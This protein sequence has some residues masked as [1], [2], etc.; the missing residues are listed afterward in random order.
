MILWKHFL[1]QIERLNGVWNFALDPDGR[2][3]RDRWF[4]KFPDTNSRMVV[5]SCW[6][7]LPELA[8]YHGKGWFRRCLHVPSEKPNLC[9]TFEGTG[10]A[11]TAWFDGKLLGRN[12][13]GC[14]PWTLAVPSVSSGA[15]ELVVMVDNSKNLEEAFPR[16]GNDWAHYGGI[17]RNV[18]A[19]FLNDVW[20]QSLQLPYSITRNGVVLKPQV[21]MTINNGLMPGRP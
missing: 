8:G 6:N 19:A 17:C 9:L 10:G 20:I 16:Y 18:E 4:A 1:R 5:P 14:L 21:G 7:I 13:I 11:A 2:G 15:H 12:P 3:M